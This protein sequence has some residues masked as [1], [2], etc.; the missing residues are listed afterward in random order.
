MK[1][2]L[3]GEESWRGQEGRHSKGFGNKRFRV[4]NRYGFTPRKMFLHQTAVKEE[5]PGSARAGKAAESDVEGEKG[6][7]AANV[8]RPGGTQVKAVNLQPP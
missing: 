6:E 8:T 2:A 5:D 1:I 7:E 3:S 4:R